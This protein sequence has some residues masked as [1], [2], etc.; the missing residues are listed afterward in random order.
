MGYKAEQLDE[1]RW[2][3]FQE[4]IESDDSSIMQQ[5]QAVEDIES[6]ITSSG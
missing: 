6:A 3:V 1:L 4:E 5:S 2:S